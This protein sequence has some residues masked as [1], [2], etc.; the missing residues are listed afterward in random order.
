[1]NQ[2]SGT[3]SQNSGSNVS[4]DRKVRIA[5]MR[6]EPRTGE[7][8]RALWPHIEP[9]LPAILE[10]FY[11]HVGSVPALTKLVGAESSRLK[12]A[13]SRHWKLLFEGHFDESYMKAVNTIGQ[14]HFRIDLEPR[15]YIGGYNYV[16]GH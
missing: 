12:G 6:I 14:V 10:G 1:M 5:F 16:L 8:L 3:A 7:L 11:S 9:K 15:W 4:L 2:P 13:Q